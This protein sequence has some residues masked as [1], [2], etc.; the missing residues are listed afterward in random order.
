MAMSFFEP[1]YFS[2]S[3]IQLTVYEL[4]H[5]KC[6]INLMTEVPQEAG[7]QSLERSKL[8]NNWIPVSG[9]LQTPAIYNLFFLQIHTQLPISAQ[10]FQAQIEN[11]LQRSA[12]G[13]CYYYSCWHLKCLNQYAGFGTVFSL[14][15]FIFVLKVI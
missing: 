11:S 15:F 7:L 6:V 2:E 9:T 4:N 13:F 3:Y 5:K 10:V 14:L 1:S 12:D 8:R